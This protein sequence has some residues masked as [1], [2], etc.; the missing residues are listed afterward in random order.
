MTDQVHCLIAA[1]G[2]G[3]RARLQYPKTLYPIKGKEIIS[4]ILDSINK[5]DSEPTIIVS[6]E[7]KHPIQQFLEKKRINAHLVVQENAKGMGDAVLHF[8]QS[9]IASKAKNILLIW[10][11]IPF[12]QK[13]TIE[14]MIHSHIMNK[15]TFTFVT[16]T[17]DYAYT[18]VK[19]DWQGKV[20]EVV[21]TREYEI[22][23]RQGERDI[24][25]FIFKK[26]EIMALLKKDLKGKYGKF[27][28]EHG[29]LYIIKHLVQSGY[30]VEALP[31]AQERELI[32]LNS[33]SDLNE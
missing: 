20:L 5:Y 4:Y 32:S 7:G 27:T 11:D 9:P 10:G 30:I 29:F 17:V 23:P 25:L 21:E 33:L 15:N 1:A 8:D 2:K 6:K 22:D 3:S 16:R 31:I 26:A 28:Q 24:G 19:R 18:I 12:I 13:E 14:R